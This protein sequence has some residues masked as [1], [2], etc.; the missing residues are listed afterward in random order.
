MNNIH[1]YF[2]YNDTFNDD[3]ECMIWFTYIEISAYIDMSLIQYICINLSQ[4]QVWFE[5]VAVKT[6][7]KRYTESTLLL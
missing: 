6:C 3:F 2:R 1:H 7:A 5:I 4:T